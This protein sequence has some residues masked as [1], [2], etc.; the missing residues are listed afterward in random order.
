MIPIFISAEAITLI[1]PTASLPAFKEL[2]QRGANTWDR[3]PA[4][5]KD[6]ADTLISGGS[7]QDY[8]SQ[9]YPESLSAPTNSLS[10]IIG[11]LSICPECGG[12]GY[13]HIHTCPNLGT[14]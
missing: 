5:I 10:T 1:V 2:V 11:E 6:F 7:W 9:Q 4:E 12:K 13:N 3:A 8:N 14:C